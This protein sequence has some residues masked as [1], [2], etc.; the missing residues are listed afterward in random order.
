MGFA[1][2]E[3]LGIISCSQFSQNHALLAPQN[4]EGP[5]LWKLRLWCLSI[6]E[7]H[8]LWIIRREKVFKHVWCNF[9]I[10]ATLE[11]LNHW[12]SWSPILNFM[13]L[14]SPIW[15]RTKQMISLLTAR[16][17]CIPVAYF[18]AVIEI[19][20]KCFQDQIWLKFLNLVNSPSTLFDCLISQN[21][22]RVWS[23]IEAIL[24]CQHDEYIEEIS[25]NMGTSMYL[26]K[27]YTTSSVLC[28]ERG[29]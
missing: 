16:N 12:Y 28:H 4:Q 23:F 29:Q 27:N 8:K 10:S 18:E 15:R 11:C 17:F 21:S 2:Y 20:I 13:A 14:T 19:S 7:D 26:I 3:F 24:V 22:R 6:E 25:Q 1:S 5:V 9:I